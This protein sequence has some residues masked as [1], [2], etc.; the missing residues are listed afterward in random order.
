MKRAQKED[1]AD[2][3]SFPDAPGDDQR[4]PQMWMTREDIQV[5][6][7]QSPDEEAGDE[8]LLEAWL[9]ELRPEPHVLFRHNR[10]S[11]AK[12]A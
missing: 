3:V 6:L 1:E 2:M 5:H 7:V 11:R 9:A 4:T 12:Q 8:G 10:Q